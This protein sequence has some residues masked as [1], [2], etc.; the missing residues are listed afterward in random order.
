MDGASRL[1]H[2]C[3]EKNRSRLYNDSQ[4]QEGRCA[5]SAYPSLTNVISNKGFAAALLTSTEENWGSP[6][7][8]PSVKP[9][10]SISM[11]PPESQEEDKP[12]EQD[13]A[14]HNLRND[15]EIDNRTNTN[16]GIGGIYHSKQSL[17]RRCDRPP[18]GPGILND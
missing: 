9:G 18:R 8:S 5:A 3:E 1:V 16:S 11:H 10:S 13:I 14:T 15:C 17:H 2:D 12:L 7:P 4:E 6:S